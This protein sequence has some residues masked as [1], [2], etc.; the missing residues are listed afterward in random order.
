MFSGGLEIAQKKGKIEKDRFSV[1]MAVSPGR[2]E[3]MTV[4][5]EEATA[6]PETDGRSMANDMQKLLRALLRLPDED[7]L[8]LFQGL[9]EEEWRTL[10]Q[11]AAVS[12]VDEQ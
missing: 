11:D 10:V 1:Q 9:P 5:D 3:A 7:L 6:T 4:R 2:A 12:V 8:F